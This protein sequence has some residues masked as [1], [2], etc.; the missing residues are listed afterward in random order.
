MQLDE[1]RVRNTRNIK[2]TLLIPGQELTVIA[3]DNG[4]GK[5]SLLES[6]FLL[7]GSKS[8][9]GSKDKEL[10]RREAPCG[11]L[12]ARA[13]T[14]GRESKIEIVI[15]DG[16]TGRRGRYAKVNGVEYGRAAE[17]AGIFTAVVFEPNHLS[18]IKSGPEGRRR[19]LDAALCQLYP[20]Y[21]GILRRFSRAL[22]QKN[23]L[24]RHYH[25]TTDAE[26]ML[27]AFDTALAAAGAEIICRR[28]SYLDS[29]GPAAE[30]FYQELSGGAEQLS[31]QY[32]PC[33]RPQTLAG[34][35]AIARSADIR[36]G[37]STFGPQREDFEVLLSGQS[38]RTYGSQGQ[39]RSAVL[40]LKL[41]EAEVARQVSGEAPVLLLDDVLSELDEGRQAY[42]LSRMGGR[43][44][45]VTCCDAS[46]FK[47]TAG[48]IVRIENG[49]ITEQ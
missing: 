42:L 41:A 34:R 13:Q 9:R 7:T 45:F 12:T 11:L 32:T 15:E 35:Y 38:A 1:L 28:A 49:A 37:F 44:S 24:L 39:Q 46:I 2:D 48:K 19:F 14:D 23:A 30:G 10:V 16:S 22:T 6:I 8:F 25:Q 21:V 17:I 29:A 5:T 3:G 18:L 47:R 26:G 20:G 40:A 31:I 33:A 43:Q 4:Q 36:A 27:D